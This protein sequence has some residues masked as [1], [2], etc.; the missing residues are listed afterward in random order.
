MSRCSIDRVTDL[1]KEMLVFRPENR[2]TIANILSRWPVKQPVPSLST[3][4][5]EIPP[6]DF[7]K[8]SKSTDV[9]R[10]TPLA[11]THSAIM[12]ETLP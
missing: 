1:V 3:L 10:H 11:S 7:Q 9:A 5:D 8:G 12:E 2:P 6:K 4:S